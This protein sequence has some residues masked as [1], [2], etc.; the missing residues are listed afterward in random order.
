MCHTLQT[1]TV[2][3]HT[4][5]G[6]GL[7][8]LSFA[9]P[10]GEQS[11]GPVHSCA[12]PPGGRWRAT[13]FFVL[14]KV[15]PH[16]ESCLRIMQWFAVYGNWAESLLP[17]LQTVTGFSTPVLVNSACWGTLILSGTL[18]ILRPHCHTQDSAPLYHWA[19]FRQGNLSL[20]LISK[21]SDF[22]HWGYI[23]L[24]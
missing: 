22:A 19:P 2:H 13:P 3:A 24:Q 9:G 23:T 8:F 14:C 7:A 16:A 17:G 10:Q 6:G 4:N 12:A 11:P 15:S 18:G 21:G 5:L 20:E 1:P